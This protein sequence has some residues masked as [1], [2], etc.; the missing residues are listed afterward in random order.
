MNQTNKWVVLLLTAFTTGGGIAI[1]AIQGGCKLGMAIAIGAIAG[2]SAILHNL[3]PSANDQSPVDIQ[4]QYNAE[5]NKITQGN[6]PETPPAIPP[7]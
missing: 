2:A 5:L 4:A 6:K 3:S 1:G 7:K